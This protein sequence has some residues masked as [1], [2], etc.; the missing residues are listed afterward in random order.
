M[1]PWNNRYA[2]LALLLLLLGTSTGGAQV[3]SVGAHGTYDVVL[4]ARFGVESADAFGGMAQLRF[5]AGEYVVLSVFGGYQEYA[6][7]QPNELPLWGWRFWD[8]RYA[9]I[10]RDNLSADT[11]LRASFDTVQTMS[12][13]PVGVV[14]GTDLVPVEDFTVR[15]YVG[16]AV[17]FYTRKL[18]VEETWSKYYAQIGYQFAYSYRNFANSKSGNPLVLLAGV[19]LSYRVTEI[20]A[21]D[22]GVRYNSVVATPGAMGYDQFPFRSSLGL[23]LGLSFLY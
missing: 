9:G 13:I 18:Y 4:S 20:V 15:P 14:V 10:V 17:Y 7:E 11:T 23:N 16:A 8:E 22:A 19:E 12:V 21:I 3:L 2:A 6:I 1:R 5:G